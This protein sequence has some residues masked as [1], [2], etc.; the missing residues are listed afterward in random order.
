MILT[1]EDYH[2]NLKKMQV[3]R[4]LVKSSTKAVSATKQSEMWVNISPTII[5]IEQKASSIL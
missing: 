1:I 5:C 4:Q 2:V 3:F